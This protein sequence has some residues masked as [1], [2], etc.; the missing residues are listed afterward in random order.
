MCRVPRLRR[1]VAPPPSLRP[2]RPYRLLRLVAVPARPPPRRQRR[3]S[4]VQS[5]EPGED[6]FLD[7]ANQHYTVAR[8]WFRRTITRSISPCRD[9][10]VACPDWKRQLH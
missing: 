10:R 5:F 7:Y 8:R 1:L 3:A 9:Q 4:H 6:W 2:L